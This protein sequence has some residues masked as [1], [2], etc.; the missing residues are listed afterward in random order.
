VEFV[1]VGDL[2]V[3]GVLVDLMEFVEGELVVR[4]VV[5]ECRAEGLLLLAVVVIL[6]N[7]LCALLGAHFNFCFIVFIFII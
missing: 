6:G 7:V 2:D 3:G 4:V 1:A 5:V